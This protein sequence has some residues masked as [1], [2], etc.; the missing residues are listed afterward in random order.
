MNWTYIII[1]GS[2]VTVALLA[3]IFQLRIRHK[4]VIVRGK[5]ATIETL[6]E[7]NKWLQEQL[8]LAKE[9]SPDVVAER[10][11]KRVTLLEDEIERL[12][13]DQDKNEALIKSKEAELDKAKEE[14]GDLKSQI[15]T[16]YEILGE[17]EYFKEQ[18]GCPYCGSELT[19]LAGDEEEYRSYSC[20]YIDSASRSSPC[21]HD[22]DFPKLEDYEL[23]TQFNER[24]NLWYCF[25]KA[26]KAN[27]KKLEL[28]PQ[29]GHTEQEAKERVIN[30]HK[31]HARNVPK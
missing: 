13:E 30:S 7:K 22:P 27:A 20:G 4:D 18:F 21:P 3:L 14:V 10:L 6:T 2:G 12:S 19:T 5:D 16:A 17:L 31:Y 28:G 1:A 11:S 29:W 15:E 24:T 8:D 25:P 9:D 26:K 23:D